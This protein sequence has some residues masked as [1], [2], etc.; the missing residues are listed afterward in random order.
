MPP[1]PFPERPADVTILRLLLP[2]LA[3]SAAWAAST[4]PSRLAASRVRG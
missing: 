2:F 3:S 1:P 4:S